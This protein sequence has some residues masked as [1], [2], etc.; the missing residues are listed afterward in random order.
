M[1]NSF[2]LS[3]FRDQATGAG[4]KGTISIDA[5]SGR[6]D[7]RGSGGFGRESERKSGIGR[8]VL[9]RKGALPA[10]EVLVRKEVRRCSESV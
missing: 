2:P 4:P 6:E 8:E 9:A 3:E 10:S 5:W 1:S 7:K